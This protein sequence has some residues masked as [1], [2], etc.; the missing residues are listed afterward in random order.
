MKQ[1]IALTLLLSMLTACSR[2]PV[3]AQTINSSEI[4]TARTTPPTHVPSPTDMF[5][6][7]PIVSATATWF[8]GQVSIEHAQITYYDITGSTAKELRSS[9][10]ESGPRDSSDGNKP[11]DAFTDWYI[12]WNWPGY[13]T[14]KCDLSAASVTYRIKV[15]MPR[16]EAP[17]DASPELVSKWEKYMQAL[18]FHEQEHVHIIAD[19]YLSVKTAIQDATCSTAEAAAQ[20][21]LDSLRELN[22]NYDRETKHGETQGAVFH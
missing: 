1:I 9:M 11:V 19:N 6:P 13:G 10:D 15:I 7:V 3:K 4:Q 5:T 16:W 8:I 22:S 2:A 12:S 18:A 21:A 20:K 17:A 14:E